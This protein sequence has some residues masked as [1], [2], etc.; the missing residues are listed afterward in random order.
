MGSGKWEPDVLRVN[1]MSIADLTIIK[2]PP[3]VLQYTYSHA[4]KKPKMRRPGKA[5]N[6]ITP[7]I[8]EKAEKAEIAVEGADHL[9]R[10]IRIENRLEDEQGNEV[11]LKEG[12]DV[13]V[14]VEA[15]ADATVPAH[16][17]EKRPRRD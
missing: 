4:M 17:T 6:I 12:A 10:E 14:V 11:K 3:K 9:Y 5:E 8:R 1:A 7:L 2:T 15:D 13:D 16:P